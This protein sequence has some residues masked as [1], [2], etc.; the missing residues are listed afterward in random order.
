MK[1]SMLLWEST[2]LSVIWWNWYHLSHMIYTSYIE[3]PFIN[4][5]VRLIRHLMD[6]FER[7]SEHLYWL[8][9]I[10]LTFWCK[11]KWHYDN[12]NWHSYMWVGHWLMVIWSILVISIICPIVIVESCLTYFLSQNAHYSFFLNDW[13]Q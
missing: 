3:I 7:S 2:Y 6:N 12:M 11:K 9:R 5:N 8:T 13:C 1:S 4:G 10:Q